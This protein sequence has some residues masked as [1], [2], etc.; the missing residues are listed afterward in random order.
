MEGKTMTHYISVSEDAGT[1]GK[2][3]L[4]VPLYDAVEHFPDIARLNKLDN[5]LLFGGYF[6][7]PDSYS[8]LEGQEYMKMN[9]VFI[10]CDNG[11]DG[12]PLTWDKDIIKKF[13]ADMEKYQYVIWETYSSTPERPKFRALIP[14][15]ATLNYTKDVKQ[16][17]FQMFRDY[18]DPRASWFFAPDTRHLP[19][20]CHKADGELFPSCHIRRLADEIARTRSLFEAEI[21]RRCSMRKLFHL[22]A[23][24]NP[25]G[26]R[27]FDTV[28][29]CLEGLV[30]GERDS[31]LNAACYAMDKNGYREHIREFL[32]EVCCDHS[33]KEKFY[34]KYR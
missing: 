4:R 19:T 21:E 27:K 12:Q 33:I 17:V 28:T 26:W 8:R 24:H 11:K 20:V 9:V 6:D 13:K 31:S 22:D 25:E 7:V 29:K 23:E 18:A 1:M 15:D 14:L 34:H 5:T 3:A 32:D 10:D 16:A 2:T 30:E